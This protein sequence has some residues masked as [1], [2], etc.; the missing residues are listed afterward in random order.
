MAVKREYGTEHPFIKLGIFKLRI[1]FYHLRWEWPEAIQGVIL[2]AVALG[3]ISALQQSL[4]VP[5]E[6]A[7]IMVVLNGVMYLLHPCLGDPTFPGWITPAIPIVLAWTMNYPE[8]TSRIHAVIALQLLMAALFIFMGVTGLADKIVSFV[9]LSMRAGIILGAGIAA[10]ISRMT[11]GGPFDAQPIT[12]SIGVV[13]CYLVMFSYR[14]LSKKDTNS[15]VKFLSKYGMLPG[16]IVAGIVGVA[17]GELPIPRP[18]MGFTPVWRFPELLRGYT[19][20]G[21]GFPPL[22]TFINALPVMFACYIIAFGDFVLA[23]VVTNDADE[24]RQDEII[25]FNPNRSN[26]ISGIR[27]LILA[28]FAPYAPLNGPL[29]AGGTIANAE[30]YKHGRDQMDTIFSGLMSFTGAMAVAG[31][32]TPIV[33]TLKPVLPLALALTMIVQGFACG[34]I[35]M[36]MVYTKEERGVAIVMGVVLAIRSAAMGLA[37]GIILHLLIGVN[38]EAKAKAEAALAGGK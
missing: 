28:I 21:H 32:I 10:I 17:L 12:M 18:E 29:W 30:R 23:E 7:T 27:N 25:D 19:M 33:T 6:L 26:L 37:V 4:G 13:V 24:V 34:Y 5:F 35:G 3:A 15:F 22:S 36:E 16:L 11:P 9:P 8:G 20:F 38:E 2:V 1:P 31:F 14:F